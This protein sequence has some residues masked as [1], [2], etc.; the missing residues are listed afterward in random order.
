MEIDPAR[1]I[2]IFRMGNGSQEVLE[3][4]DFKNVS[5]GIFWNLRWLWHSRPQPFQKAG[6]R[7]LY[8]DSIIFP[9]AKICSV[10]SLSVKEWDST[11][12]R[13]VSW[14]ICVCVCGSHSGNSVRQKRYF[15]SPSI[16]M[17][18]KSCSCVQ[19]VTP[20]ASPSD[21][22][23]YSPSSTV[24]YCEMLHCEAEH[25]GMHLSP[26]KHPQWVVIIFARRSL[27]M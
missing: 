19:E 10:S 16:L 2:E 17:C 27:W 1:H 7:L 24:I 3:V 4:H 13:W 21:E 5:D 18:P 22:C 9:F 8:N 15:K 25:C 23:S 6:R 11:L 26:I 12:R 20:A 14:T